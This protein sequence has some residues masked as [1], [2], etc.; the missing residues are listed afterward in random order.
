MTSNVGPM[1]EFFKTSTTYS[2]K[3]VTLMTISTLLDCRKKIIHAKISHENDRM[4]FH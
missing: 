1:V 3:H 4:L 2:I